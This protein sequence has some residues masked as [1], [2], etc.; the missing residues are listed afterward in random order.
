M[1]L[2]TAVGT[3]ERD[4]WRHC[5]CWLQDSCASCEWHWRWS[6]QYTDQSNNTSSSSISTG[7]GD[8]QRRLQLCQVKVGRWQE[9]RPSPLCAWDATR[10]LRKVCIRQFLVSD[11]FL[12]W[13]STVVVFKGFLGRTFGIWSNL[14]FISQEIWMLTKSFVTVHCCVPITTFRWCRILH[15]TGHLHTTTNR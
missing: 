10:R 15:T 1:L 13:Q 4:F 6:I 14:W 12:A 11:D 2:L 9:R 5:I 3:K 7:A 8:H